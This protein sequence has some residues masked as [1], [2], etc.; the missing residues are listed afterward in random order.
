MRSILI[1][2]ISGV[3]QQGTKAKRVITE[4]GHNVVGT[5]SSDSLESNT[6]VATINLV[7]ATTASTIILK[8]QRVQAVWLENVKGPDQG[9]RGATYAATYSLFMQ[10]AVFLNYIK[11][12]KGYITRNGSDSGKLYVLVIDGHASQV[13]IAVIELARSLNMK[14]F[15]LIS[16]S[17][18]ATQPLEVVV[19]GIFK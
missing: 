4:R 7:S 1:P 11:R 6:V 13:N 15:Q 16:L 10:G 8:G 19:F 17:S 14:L 18:H 9:P 3:T 12:F 2:T 5:K